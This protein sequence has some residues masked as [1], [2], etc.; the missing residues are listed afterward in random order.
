MNTSFIVDEMLGHI[1]R[2]L[3]IAGYDVKFVNRISDVDLLKLAI[4]GGR[5]LITSDKEL[6]S[7]ARKNG[8]KVIFITSSDSIN[9]LSYIAASLSLPMEPRMVR[10]T[11]C[12]GLLKLWEGGPLNVGYPIPGEGKDLWVCETC[13]R[14]YWKGTHWVSM[15]KFLRK[16]SE[17][18]HKMKNI[19]KITSP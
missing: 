18:A 4:G 2:W 5:T 15:C 3:R 19:N 14:V 17:E 1:A 6:A 10:C 13:G 12:N 7:K 9:A 16:V 11:V 8:V